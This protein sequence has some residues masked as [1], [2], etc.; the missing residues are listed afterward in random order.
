MTVSSGLL[1]AAIVEKKKKRR[2]KGEKLEG[3]KIVREGG[4]LVKNWSRRGFDGKR[5]RQL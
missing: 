1:R 4:N 3:K 2:R 5:W